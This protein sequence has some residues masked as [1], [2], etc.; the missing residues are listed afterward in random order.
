MRLALLARY[1]DG[2]LWEERLCAAFPEAAL[3][4]DEYNALSALSGRAAAYDAA[5]VALDGPDG[6][7]AVRA[8]REQAPRQPILWIADEADYA[9]FAFRYRVTA[10]LLHDAPAAALRHALQELLHE[11]GREAHEHCLLRH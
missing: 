3:P 9:V 2:D 6:L 4:V 7:T 1:L 5:V 11:S 10:F 8:L